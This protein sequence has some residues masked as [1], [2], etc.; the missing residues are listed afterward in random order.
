MIKY[1]ANLFQYTRRHTLDVNVGRV[2]MGSNFPVVVQSMTTTKTE[3]TASSVAQSQRIAQAGG[4]IVR[5]T[6]QGR[7]QAENL[8]E[9]RAQLRDRKSVV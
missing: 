5:L 4:E 8:G 3:D 2:R 7:S 9:I 6:A 1:C